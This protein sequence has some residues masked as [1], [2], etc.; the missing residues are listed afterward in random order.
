VGTSDCLLPE[1][2]VKERFEIA[3]LYIARNPKEVI[4][5]Q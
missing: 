3:N 1:I 4:D 5:G 2:L